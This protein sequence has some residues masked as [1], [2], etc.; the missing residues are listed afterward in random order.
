MW[1]D[2]QFRTDSD[3]GNFN[4]SVIEHGEIIS[5][6]SAHFSVEPSNE[7]D[8]DIYLMTGNNGKGSEKK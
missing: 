5:E 2:K 3:N 4:E 8:Y 6:R 7:K 1:K